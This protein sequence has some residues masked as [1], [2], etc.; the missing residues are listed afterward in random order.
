MEEIWKDI[1][2]YEGVYQVSNLGQVKSLQMWSSVQ[3]R[4]CQREKIMKQ[5]QSTTGYFQINLKTEGTRKLGLVHRLVAQA[6][7]PNPD[8]KPQVNH[9]DGNK[10]N[11]S[12]SN[13]EWVTNAENMDHARANGLHEGHQRFCN[14]KK[15][16]IIAIHIESG[17]E[18]VFDSILSAGKAI[19]TTHIP[20]VL[21][22]LRYE[23]KGYTFRYA[24]EVMPD[25]DIDNRSAE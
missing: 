8:N 9:K 3:R 14:S 4:Y 6:F 2:G 20:Q 23:A 24:K 13:L 12:V 10:R 25:A 15:K 21:Q 16:R 19:G 11:N 7:I 5:Y 22:G 18:I 1:P 17:E